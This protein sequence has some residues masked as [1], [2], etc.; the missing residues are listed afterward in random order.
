MSVMGEYYAQICKRLGVDPDTSGYSALCSLMLVSPFIA[1][2]KS[3]EN[4]IERALYAR[5]EYARKLS[6][7][8]RTDFYEAMGPCSVLEIIASLVDKLSYNLINN[9]LA[10]DDPGALFF[11]L[12]DNLG[13]TWL[14]DDAFGRDAEACNGSFEDAMQTFIYR[15]YDENGNDGGLFPVE[16][17]A[18]DMREM[19]LHRQ[20]EE[21]LIDR[22]GALD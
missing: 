17:A 15:E 3:D 14:N 13:L 10:S 22:F 20:M 5:R 9:P 8:E 1:V 16:K 4:E 21:Y 12:M 7:K 18:S 11:E 19:S 2:L 6:T